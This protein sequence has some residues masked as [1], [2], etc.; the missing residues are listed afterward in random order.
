MELFS[1]TR[2][3]C[4]TRTARTSRHCCAVLWCVVDRIVIDVTRKEDEAMMDATVDA[5]NFSQKSFSLTARSL[6]PLCVL[7]CVFRLRIN[8]QTIVFETIVRIQQILLFKQS[9]NLT[10]SAQCALPSSGGG[11][12]SGISHTTSITSV[13]HSETLTLA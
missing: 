9:K 6:L 8:I 4:S 13:S 3:L 5:D 2:S 10:T 7:F 12:N 11:C 1:L